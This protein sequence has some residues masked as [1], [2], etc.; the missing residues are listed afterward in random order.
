IVLAL[1]GAVNGIPGFGQILSRAM[2]VLEI[3]LSV[4]Y[5]KFINNE[6]TDYM[7]VFFSFTFKDL[8]KYLNHLGTMLARMLLIVLWMLLF[9]IPGIIKAIAYSQVTYI[10]AENPDMDIME[11]LKESQRLMDGHKMEYFVMQ[12]SFI[13]W[14]LLICITFGLAAIYV[15]P[16]H[17]TTMALYYR[18]LTP[19]IEIIAPKE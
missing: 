13:G 7:D 14:F 16:Y 1:S 8:N 9:I 5:L 2:L 15:L 3:G 10:K 17:A 11:C 6:K 4:F 19:Q 12:L 18:A